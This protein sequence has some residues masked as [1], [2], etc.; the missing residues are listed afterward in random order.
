MGSIVKDKLGSSSRSGKGSRNS[1]A[2]NNNNAAEDVAIAALDSVL[3]R[4]H[5]GGS[6][7]RQQQ[8]QQIMPPAKLLSKSMKNFIISTFETD[9]QYSTFMLI[10]HQQARRKEA[11]TAATHLVGARRPFPPLIPLPLPRPLL[12]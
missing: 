5:S 6:T 3:D 9:S 11:R 12:A 8:Q 10:L 1:S 2:H 7:E 4:Y